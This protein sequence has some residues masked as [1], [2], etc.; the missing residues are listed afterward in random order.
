MRVQRVLVRRLLN[1]SRSFSCKVGNIKM[2]RDVVSYDLYK[3]G[4]YEFRQGTNAKE[5][6][7]KGQRDI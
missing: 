6:R 3:T 2:D 5:E 4:S 7:R 1:A